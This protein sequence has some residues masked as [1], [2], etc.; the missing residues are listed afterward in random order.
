MNKRIYLTLLL[1]SS[2]VFVN[3]QGITAQFMDNLPMAG[4]NRASFFPKYRYSTSI[5]PVSNIYFE[6]N[7]SFSVKDIIYKVEDGV[8][9]INIGDFLNGMPKVNFF[10]TNFN[11][12]LFHTSFKIKNNF[13]SVG[14]TSKTFAELRIPRDVFLLAWKGN[15]H[16]IGN[17]A[18]LDNIG[19]DMRNYNELSIGYTRNFNDAFHI[20]GK[21]KLLQGIM[22][23]NTERS[24]F[25]ITTDTATYWLNMDYSF[26]MNIAGPFDTNGFEGINSPSDILGFGNFGLGF[27]I[28]GDMNINEKFNLG[29]S[30]VD[31]GYI[32]WKNN[33]KSYSI[34]NGSLSFRGIEIDT[35]FNFDFGDSAI[36]VMTD[37]LMEKFQ[38]IR[39]TEPFLTPL[40]TRVYLFANYKINDK[41]KA[42]AIYQSRLG[43]KYNQMS[44]SLLYQHRL[45]K[46][47]DINASYTMTN[48]GYSKIGTG[49]TFRIM[50][51]HFYYVTDDIISFFLPQNAKSLSFNFGWYYVKGNVD[52]EKKKKKKDTAFLYKPSLLWY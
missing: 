47:F 17:R 7:T 31:I 14:L 51:S 38:P 44:L 16:Y 1:I 5:T 41:N 34:D 12:E 36:K 45:L 15:G 9:H 52:K 27:D 30:V 26:K 48:L 29:M 11:Y 24:I 39:S 19:I 22:N 18:S 50:G 33:V 3:A 35:S 13:F 42:G 28:G 21:L 43:G 10:N 32:Q 8:A 23:V 4:Y 25:G 37:T 6:M 49:F 20:G 46:F 2:V 40:N